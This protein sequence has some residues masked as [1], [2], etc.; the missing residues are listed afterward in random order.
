MKLNF[1][2]IIKINILQCWWAVP[3]RDLVP[4]VQLGSNTSYYF[5]RTAPASLLH[6]SRSI[7]FREARTST[8]NENE[9]AH[10]GGGVYKSEPLTHSRHFL[11]NHS[12]CDSAAGPAK[13]IHPK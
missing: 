1:L 10:R 3:A 6:R 4:G 13:F 11:L 8:A 9:A 2:I 12:V 7:Q 5:P